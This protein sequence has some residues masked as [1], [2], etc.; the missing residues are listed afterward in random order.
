[1]ITA[2]AKGTYTISITP[3]QGSGT[4]ALTVLDASQTVLASG[5][6]ATGSDNLSVTLVSGQQVYVK[7]NSPTGSL[8]TYNLSIG[9]SGGGGG[10]RGGGGG[11]HLTLQGAQKGDPFYQNAADDPDGAHSGP[12]S[13]GFVAIPR[14]TTNAPLVLGMSAGGVRT[15][16]AEV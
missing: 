10:G 6:S 2:G 4:L 11:K 3:T 1:S 8:F 16:A 14:L 12:A 7:V 15:I 9:I 13:P 5:Q